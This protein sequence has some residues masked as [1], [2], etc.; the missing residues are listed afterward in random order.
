MMNVY[1]DLKFVTK[2]KI[3]SLES[4]RNEL[5]KTEVKTIFGGD[6]VVC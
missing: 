1:A 3:A 5:G 2:I 6:Q 4:L